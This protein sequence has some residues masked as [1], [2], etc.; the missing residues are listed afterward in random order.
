VTSE[1]LPTARALLARAFDPDR[2]RLAA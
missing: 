1:D 2:A